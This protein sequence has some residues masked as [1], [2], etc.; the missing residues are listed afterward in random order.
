MGQLAVKQSQ[1]EQKEQEFEMRRYQYA[2]I[3]I[4]SVLVAP[5]ITFAASK[6]PNVLF[7]FTDDQRFDALGVH[8]PELK[9]PNMDR[10]VRG[11]VCFT[12]AHI[13]G[14]TRPAVCMPSR[15][16]LMTGRSLFHITNDGGTIDPQHVTLPEAFRQA[17][18][19][20]FA[21]GKW[22]ND[23]AAFA[24]SFTHGGKIFFG[25][26]SDHL[27]VPVYDF[28]PTGKYPNKNRYFAKKFSSELFSDAAIDFLRAH[29]ADKPF[30]AYV[31]YTAPHDPRMAPQSYTDMYPP[32]RITLPVNFLPEH[33]FDNGELKIRDEMLAPF[34]RTQNVVR[35]HI[36]A[37]YAMISHL[38][39][40]I[41]RVLAAL[42]QTGRADNTII[43]FAGDNG[44]AVGQHGL[45]GK[46]NMYEHS[47]RIPL[48]ISG[49]GLPQ[50]KTHN[51]LCYLHDVA[52]TLCELADI[53][54]PTSMES[55]SLLPIVKGE[56]RKHRESVFYAY[57]TFQRG[58]RGGDWKL[59]AYNVQG[60]QA[61]QLFNL[62]NDPMEM[63]NLAD[64]PEQARR[65]T[66]MTV[67]LTTWM[68]R[69][70][71]PCDASQPDW[72]CSEPAPKPSKARQ[73]K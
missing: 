7:L 66:E 9:T 50:G 1:E 68:R 45:L 24:R 5:G 33:P 47:V 63:N 42:K 11:G 21:T 57:R 23:K 67:M 35:E 6:R 19:A 61:I 30:F 51:A 46:Q 8:C 37:Y 56:R 62:K 20:T 52:P 70:D 27:K 43:V 69:M 53:P 38:D 34:P 26:M 4:L 73:A 12:H 41:G 40:Q 29:D 58:V 15:A 36:A 2:L 59:I 32:D 25:G 14:S 60:K 13:M 72:G 31:S 54:I 16:M 39:A 17:G 71:D 22:H 3:A 10:L 55:K 48:V 49:P 18:Y 44:L 28:D 65:A 64:D